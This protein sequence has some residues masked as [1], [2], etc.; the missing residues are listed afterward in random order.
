MW[1]Y[2][3]LWIPLVFI[4][5]ANGVVR[6]TWYGSSLS[7][8]RAHQ[9]STLTGILFFGLYMWVVLRWF[10]PA[11]AG[12]ALTIGLLWLGL[13][14]AFEFLFGHYVAGHPW[15]RLLQDY[16]LFEGRLWVVVLVWVTLAPSLF[17]R[18]R[19]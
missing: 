15:S 4:A 8:L 17:Y 7:E 6:Q 19:G 3:L 9:L 18:W 11:A 2:V 12:Q 16:H 5:I 13:T 1:K 10:Q 14:V